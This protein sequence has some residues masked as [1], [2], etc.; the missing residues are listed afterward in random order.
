[1][2]AAKNGQGRRIISEER[3]RLGLPN[4]YLEKY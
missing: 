3:L 2:I 4:F 1:M